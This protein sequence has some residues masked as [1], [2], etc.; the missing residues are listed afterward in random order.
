VDFVE[1]RNC[2]WLR[3]T[4]SDLKVLIVL[5][6][7]QNHEA[8][9]IMYSDITWK[10]ELF[11]NEKKIASYR[12]HAMRNSKVIKLSLQMSDWFGIEAHNLPSLFSNCLA[13]FSA[14]IFCGCYLFIY[15]HF[16]FIK[17]EPSFDINW[18]TCH[19]IPEVSHVYYSILFCFPLNS[20]M[21]IHMQNAY[22]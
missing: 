4:G 3:I 10:H 19:V 1:S 20:N 7:D 9:M 22:H 2:C 15:F 8:M 11:S 6:K 17:F 14:C 16:I 21:Q 18:I 5:S 12:F 13:M